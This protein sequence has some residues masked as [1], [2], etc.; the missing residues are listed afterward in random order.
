M[1]ER[2]VFVMDHDK[3]NLSSYLVFPLR[4][5]SFGPTK[6]PK[7]IK[8]LNLE[9]RLKRYNLK[10]TSEGKRLSAYGVMIVLEYNT[11]HLLLLKGPQKNRFELPGGHVRLEESEPEALK[12][13]ISK[14]L[15][16]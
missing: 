7:Q 10:F 14:Q 4:N 16:L 15:L 6:K 1:G 11:P 2:T 5:Y 9:D 3:N 8:D 13:K 12:R